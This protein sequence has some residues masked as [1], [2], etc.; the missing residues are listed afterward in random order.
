MHN[1]YTTKTYIS[2]DRRK[3]TE[4]DMKTTS[5]SSM[6]KMTSRNGNAGC[7]QMMAYG[8]KWPYTRTAT[9]AEQ[10]CLD[11]SGRTYL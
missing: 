4:N 9:T 11:I 6:D 5:A 1:T 3:Q 8:I 10:P 2:S 7:L